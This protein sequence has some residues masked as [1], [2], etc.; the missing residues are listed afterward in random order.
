[1]RDI[2]EASIQELAEIKLWLFQENVRV[3]NMR[4]EV[5]Q[6]RKN[7]EN[8]R[9]I[10]MEQ[11][12]EQSRRNEQLNRE[13]V[14]ERQLFNKKWDVLED[15]FRKLNEDKKQLHRERRN[16]QYDRERF[17]EERNRY[18]SESVRTPNG[19]LA[20][21]FRGVTN[22]KTLKK[23]YKDLIKMFHP[24]NQGG[25]HDL[26]QVINREYANLRTVYELEG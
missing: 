1:M 22:A 23:R 15:G 13:L 9:Q 20:L 19:E 11:I 4:Q 16:L 10:L 8:E 7:V 24:D 2:N 21:L 25:D 18:R 17:L 3:E 26:I 6:Y 12:K 5:E 14:R